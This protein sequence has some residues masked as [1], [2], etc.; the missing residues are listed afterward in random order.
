[1]A[2]PIKVQQTFRMHLGVPQLEYVMRS[3]LLS[4]QHPSGATWDC[5]CCS[6]E[7][8]ETSQHCSNFCPHFKHAI[9]FMIGKLDLKIILKY[10]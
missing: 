3:F 5:S 8:N 1:M 7:F 4:S 2:C 6:K 9:T 10:L